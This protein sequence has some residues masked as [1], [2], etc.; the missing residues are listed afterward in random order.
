MAVPRERLV[1]ALSSPLGS[2]TDFNSLSTAYALFIECGLTDEV[3]EAL[4]N[5][6]IQDVRKH[7]HDAFAGKWHETIMEDYDAWVQ[8]EMLAGVQDLFPRGTDIAW[9]EIRALLSDVG[10]DALVEL[11]TTE[12][13]DIIVQYPESQ[14]ALLDLKA[15]L[16][17][18]DQRAKVVNVFQK[19]C[20]KRLLQGGATTVDIISCYISTIRAFCL[21]DPRGVLLEKVARPIRRYLK[22][23]EDTISVLIFGLLGEPSS[24]ISFLSEELAN[25]R[26]TQG[27]AIEDDLADMEWVPDPLDAPP[28]FRKGLPSD[29]VGSLISLYENREVFVKEFTAVFANR[30]LTSRNSVDDVVSFA[31]STTRVPVPRSPEN[32]K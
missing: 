20:K 22:E 28:D 6:L 27:Q 5:V 7:V 23:R 19:S 31:P 18:A 16:N 30:L 17:T 3:E 2:R 15:C 21:L 11:R 14:A 8:G 10:R 29:I 24:D 12:L 13:F 9:S 1:K 26:K 25:T 32:C 4:S